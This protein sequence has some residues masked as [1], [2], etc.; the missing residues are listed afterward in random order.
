MSNVNLTDQPRTGFP[1]E[2][3]TPEAELEALRVITGA[4][5]GLDPA[6]RR[7]VALWVADRWIGAPG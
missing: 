4:F 5:T 2:G 3:V 1:A 7:R 6:A